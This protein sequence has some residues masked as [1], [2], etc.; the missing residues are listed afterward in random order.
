MALRTTNNNDKSTNDQITATTDKPSKKRKVIDPRTRGGKRSWK[1]GGSNKNEDSGVSANS[2]RR[3]E[4]NHAFRQHRLK[5]LETEARTLLKSLGGKEIPPLSPKDVKGFLLKRLFLFSCTHGHGLNGSIK[6]CRL[7]SWYSFGGSNFVASR[8]EWESAKG[9]VLNSDG[10][11][12]FKSIFESNP[13]GPIVVELGAGFGDWI[14]DRAQQEVKSNHV[15]VELRADRVFQILSKTLTLAPRKPLE[16]VCIVGSDSGSFLSTRV[17]SPVISSI[18]A[19]HPEPPTQTFG[20]RWDVLSQIMSGVDAAEPLHMLTSDTLLAAAKCL[21]PGSGKIV[22]VTDNKWYAKLLGATFVR[23]HCVSS[24]LVRP[25]TKAEVSADGLAV[26]EKVRDNVCIY[27]K[28]TQR[29]VR[30]GSWFDRLWQTGAGT[31]AEKE[32]RFV[33]TMY[34]V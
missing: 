22:I 33:L 12:N 25:P 6:A 20:N 27:Q 26:F 1:N 13:S 31:H 11:M 17:K 14:V 2:A 28:N 16:N 15:A 9:K 18:F 19:F 32:A 7:S 24:D 3:V 30:G 10:T 8:K 4:S 5:E 29:S 34:R 21:L 23:V